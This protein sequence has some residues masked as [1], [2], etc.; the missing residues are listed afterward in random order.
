MKVQVLNLPDEIQLPIRPCRIDRTWMQQHQGRTPYKCNPM[1]VANGYGWEIVSP[2][3]FTFIWDGSAGQ[4]EVSG[5]S[6]RTK[7]INPV[8]PKHHFGNGVI[9]WSTGFV[10]RTE[11]PYAMFVTAPVNTV[12]HNVTPLSGIVETYWMPFTF[13]L[14][15]KINAPGIPTTVNQGD[16]LAQFFPVQ[17]DVFDDMELEITSM[18]NAEPEFQHNFYHWTKHRRN[19]LNQ[20]GD[21]SGHY[22]RGEVPGTTYQAENRYTK[23]RVPWPT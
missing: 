5:V 9:T 10:L 11:F 7:D 4:S 14:N 13:T 19:T 17:I 16:V 12:F 1:T 21:P 2:S 3:T 18:K 20:Q 15:W 22:I 8:L 23:I 6:I